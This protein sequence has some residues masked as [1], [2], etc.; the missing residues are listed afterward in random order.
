M[1]LFML[2]R[3]AYAVLVVLAVIFF[4]S[5]LV[6]LVPGDAVDVMMAQNPGVSQEE[7]DQLRRELG[8]DRPPL[9]QFIDYTT[10]IL[11]GDLGFSVKFR[12]PVATLIQERMLATVELALASLLMA[13]LIA[14]P[15]GMIAGLRQGSVWDYG[16][17]IFAIIGV[18]VPAFLIGI[19]LILFFSVQMNWLPPSGRKLSLFGSAGSAIANGDFK[20]FWDNARYYIMPV[21]SLP[22]TR[23]AV[24]SRLIRSAI[25]ETRRLDYVLFAKAK[26]LQPWRVNL[27]HIL[28]NALIPAVTIFGLQIGQVISGTFIIENV[29]AWPGLGRL[30]VEAINARDFPLI[31]GTVLVSAV[32]FVLMSLVVDFMYSVL[33]PRVQYG[34]N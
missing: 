14:V 27:R 32:L 9:T 10:G 1:L 19:L 3:V 16:S 22:V 2:R 4:L 8:I 17:T 6:K 25:L 24:N 18:A 5:L 30:A 11:H 29:F 15:L 26:G 33:D 34:G 31:Q 13:A 12:V 28:R 23:A 7:M 21:M 20:L